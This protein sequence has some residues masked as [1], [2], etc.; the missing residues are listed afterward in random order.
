MIDRS[1][2]SLQYLHKLHHIP[3]SRPHRLRW[4]RTRQPSYYEPGHDSHDFHDF[5]SNDLHH[6][7]N[8]QNHYSRWTD[9][10]PL[11][12]VRRPR[13]LRTHSGTSSR[14]M[15]CIFAVILM[16]VFSIVPSWKQMQQAKRLLLPVHTRVNLYRLRVVHMSEIYVGCFD[17]RIEQSFIDSSEQI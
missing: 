12:A 9:T 14:V 7:Y 13:L 6:H 3:N 15:S 10:D 11:W 8:Y 17:F 16:I 5:H 2:H 1:W 4:W